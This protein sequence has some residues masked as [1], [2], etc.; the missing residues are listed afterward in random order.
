MPLNWRFEA[1]CRHDKQNEEE[2]EQLFV[3]AVE[4]SD[5]R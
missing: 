3:A 5:D 4:S 2:R 1:V